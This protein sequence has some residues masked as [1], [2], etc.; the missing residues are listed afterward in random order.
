MRSQV[1]QVLCKVTPGNDILAGRINDSD[2]RVGDIESH[3]CGEVAT[4]S[5]RITAFAQFV[6]P[7]KRQRAVKN[8]VNVAM[9]CS[10]ES[11]F[12][13]EAERSSSTPRA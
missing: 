7:K 10:T 12:E 4:L 3:Q 6:P 2:D 1:R 11:L 13:Q 9:C 5:T 8:V